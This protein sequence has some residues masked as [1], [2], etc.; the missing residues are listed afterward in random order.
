MFAGIQI[1][2]TV[3]KPDTTNTFQ[4]FLSYMQQ[5]IWISSHSSHWLP[6]DSHPPATS[7]L[8]YNNYQPGRVKANTYLL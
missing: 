6:A 7:S 5:F 2:H 1:C 8:S 3:N 4:S